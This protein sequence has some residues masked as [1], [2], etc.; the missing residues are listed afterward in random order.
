[1]E[2][3]FVACFEATIHGVW[4]QN[5]IS[6]LEIVNNIARLLKVYC[7]NFATVFFSKND[8]YSKGAKHMEIL[9]S[10]GLPLKTYNEHVERMDTIG[11]VIAICIMILLGLL[12]DTLSSFMCFM[13][14][15]I[16]IWST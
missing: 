4:L 1:M 8:K 5:F 2:A 13:I 9:E 16:F 7:G 3:E 12:F 11:V 6:G 14:I 15:P 10:K